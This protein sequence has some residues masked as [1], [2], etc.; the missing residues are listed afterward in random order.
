MNIVDALL[1]KDLKGVGDTTILKLLKFSKV[2]KI[3]TIEELIPAI[4]KSGTLKRIP[5][6]ITQLLDTD[7]YQD[8][9]IS[10]EH[11]MKEW[12]KNNIVAIHL[13]SDFYPK[14][15]LSLESPPP[16]LFCKGNISLLEEAKAIAI[17]GTRNNTKRGA[18]I[19]TKTTEAFGN[20]GFTIVSGLALGIDT[21]AHRSALDNGSPTIAVLVDVLNVSPTSNKKLAE[22][23]IY[24]GG[25]LVSENIPGISV[26]P[27]LFAKRDRIQSGLSTAVFAIETSKD[28]G[29]MHAVRYSELMKR[30][31]FVPDADAAKYSD[32]NIKEIEG[33]QY[34][35]NTGIAK[36]YTSDSYEK[37]AN[38]LTNLADEISMNNTA[39]PQKQGKLL[40]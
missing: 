27:A 7:D 29:T 25:L 38:K 12:D 1:L 10:I 32:L 24:N 28:G 18:I 15:L 6:S 30:P 9:K 20:F 40:F 36:L 19:A 17:I 4:N 11:R 8:Q 13:C 34:L 33:T 31:I 16:F 23:I 22:E 14:R 3:K 35:A 37:I 39:I 26:I 2:N 21:I 5:K